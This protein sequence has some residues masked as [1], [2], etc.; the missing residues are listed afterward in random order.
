[1]RAISRYCS[2]SR[3]FILVFRMY[4]YVEE[5]GCGSSRM[6]RRRKRM[7]QERGEEQKCTDRLLNKARARATRYCARQLRPAAWRSRRRRDTIVSRLEKLHRGNN[8]YDS[9]RKLHLARF[10]PSPSPR[11]T[12]FLVFLS[13]YLS[14]LLSLF[15]SRLFLHSFISLSLFLSLFLAFLLFSI[16]PAR[17]ARR[18]RDWNTYA[19][20][21]RE[22]L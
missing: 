21:S 19:R 5:R 13:V 15:P 11:L 12:A 3:C 4:R 8:R 6:K 17:G 22:E 16:R 9:C 7:R 1:M 10:S 14:L 20:K 18:C 2:R